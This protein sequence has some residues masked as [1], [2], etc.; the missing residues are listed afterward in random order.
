LIELGRTP[1]PYG[2]SHRIEK[3]EVSLADGSRVELI[4]KDLRRSQLHPGAFAAK[5]DFLHDPRREVEAYRCLAGAGLGTPKCHDSGTDWLLLEKVPGVELWQVGELETWIETARWLSRLHMRL[6]GLPAPQPSLMRYDADYFRLWPARV[7]GRSPELDRVLGRYDRVVHLLCSLRTTFVHGEFYPSNVMVSG[8]RIAPVDWEMA[9][10]GPGVL[11]L[12]ALVTGWSPLER[13]AIIAGYL[14]VPAEVLAAAQL[15]LA[16][17]W[18]GW[19]S[20]WTPPP[21]HNH[22]WFAEALEAARRLGL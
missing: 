1:Y 4:F 20:D 12:A 3:V 15:H 21:E 2:T 11:D 22:D 17:Q 14:P 16:V 13:D 6:E 8:R 10:I 19:S 5:P 7:R 18:L 9:G